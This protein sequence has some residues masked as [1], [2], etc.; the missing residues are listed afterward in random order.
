M[1][2]KNTQTKTLETVA[3]WLLIALW[4]LSLL[5]VGDFVPPP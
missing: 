2:D 3:G 5:F 4:A 1:P